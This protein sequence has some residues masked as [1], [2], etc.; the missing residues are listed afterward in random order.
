MENFSLSRLSKN[1]IGSFMEENYLSAHEIE[2]LNEIIA[3]IEKGDAPLLETFNQFGHSL[4]HIYMNVYAYRNAIRFGFDSICFD[5]YGWLLRP[6]FLE[7]EEL[8]FGDKTRYGQHST[9]TIGSG[10]NRKWTYALHYSFGTAGGAWS[11]S[12]YGRVFTGRTD[13]LNA[14]I[15]DLKNRFSLVLGDPDTTNFSQPVIIRTL[16]DIAVYQNAQVQL[17]LF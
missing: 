5:K 7:R 15:A 17:S 11:L 1:D 8:V 13:A 6:E 16:R 3:A 2:I 12:V 14:G 4:R 10:P 9:L